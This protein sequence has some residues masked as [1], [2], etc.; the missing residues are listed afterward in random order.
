MCRPTRQWNRGRLIRLGEMS[1]EYTQLLHRGRQ[2]AE[3]TLAVER[4]GDAL[5]L[6][7]RLSGAAGSSTQRV[8]LTWT[9]MPLGGS[10]PWFRCGCG[11]RTAI[12]YMAIGGFACGKCLGLAYRSQSEPPAM[13]AVRKAVSVA[14]KLQM[15]LGAGPSLSERLPRWKPPWKPGRKGKGAPRGMRRGTHLR[16]RWRV[17]AA[18]ERA[19]G[20][21][22]EELRQRM[23][24]LRR[25]R[26]R[27]PRRMEGFFT[28]RV[29]AAV[30]R[31][32][33]EAARRGEEGEKRNMAKL[34]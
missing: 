25:L 6:T 27:P 18:R 10:Q 34:P 3:I 8:P 23:P 20:L 9:A 1:E 7:Y 17:I 21:E 15:Q 19:V 5:Q 22:L 14:R 16:L 33:A 12:L 28:R 30:E 2:A 31:Q 4:S 24:G 29:L 11:L 32:M 13:R 26:G